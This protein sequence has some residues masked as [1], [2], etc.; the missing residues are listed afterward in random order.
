MAI[1][2]TYKIDRILTAP[3]LNELTDVVTEIDYIYQ[4]I[5]GTGSDKITVH[6]RGT[7]TL[8]TPESDGFINYN[9]LTEANVREFVKAKVD[10]ERNKMIIQHLIELKKAPKN[11]E[12]ALPWS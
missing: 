7:V 4:G 8:E 6:V 5:E 3:L 9:D 2:Y 11:V 12:K 10:V 1:T